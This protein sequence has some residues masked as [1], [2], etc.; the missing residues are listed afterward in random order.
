MDLNISNIGDLMGVFGAL[1]GVGALIAALVNVL[2]TV[3][4]VKDG[5][6]PTVSTG[7]NLAGMVLLFAVGVIK[8]DFDLAGADKFAGDLAFVLVTVVGFVWQLI[9]SRLT[10]EQALKGI[11]VIGKSFSGDKLQAAE[12]ARNRAYQFEMVHR[13]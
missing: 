9:A 7:L 1:G 6:A 5:Q 13:E 12:A 3:G 2:K 10:H 8:P 4:V 11:G